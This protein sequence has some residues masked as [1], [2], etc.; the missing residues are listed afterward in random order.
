MS[1]FMNPQYFDN[2]TVDKY[3]IISSDD[4]DVTFW[5]NT[6]EF[7][8]ILGEEIKNIR[9]V[10]WKNVT[11]P[12]NINSFSD[13]YKN[14]KLTVGYNGNAGNIYNIS[15]GIYPD[16]TYLANAIEN[17]L[18]H[19]NGRDKFKVFYE[20]NT[21]KTW[22]VADSTFTVYNNDASFSTQDLDY[23]FTCKEGEIFENNKQLYQNS[24]NWGLGY[25]LGFK[26]ETATAV[27]TSTSISLEYLRSGENHLTSRSRSY[28]IVAK[29]KYYIQ[30]PHEIKLQPD[31]NI[32]I[33]M[34][35]QNHN[36]NN[37]MECRPYQNNVN[38][39]YNSG[40]NSKRCSNA[41]S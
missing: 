36:F 9:S 6:N 16:G 38:S 41:N 40:L 7:E 31:T 35:S 1:Q 14:T 20:P 28:T 24:Q 13:N 34:E 27:Q 33:E 12:M 8:V 19:V 22:F 4:R 29:D 17:T 23:R 11:M 10:E 25:N 30:T 18:N 21:K 37:I 15:G 3:L 26:K 2:V 5:P 32:Y 39:Q